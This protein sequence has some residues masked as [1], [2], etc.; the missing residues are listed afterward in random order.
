MRLKVF[1]MALAAVFAAASFSVAVAAPAK[2]PRTPDKRP[3]L[4]GVW[5]VLNTANWDIEPHGPRAALA[6][7]PGPVVP[8]PA[9]EVVAL[10]AVGAVPAGPGVVVGGTLPYRPDALALRNEN[11]ADWL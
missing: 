4:N 11:R 8:V 6:F 7:R 2:I 1:G 10:G 9:K 5:Q 3:D